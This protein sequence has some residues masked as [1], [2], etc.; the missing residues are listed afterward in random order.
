MSWETCP[1]CKGTGTV[2]GIPRPWSNDASPQQCEVCN[3]K[4][5]I[6]SETGKPPKD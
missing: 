5:I 4:K 3:G 6:N 1:L 2:I